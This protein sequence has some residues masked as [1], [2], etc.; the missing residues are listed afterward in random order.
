MAEGGQRSKGGEE[1]IPDADDGSSGEEES[2]KNRRDKDEISISGDKLSFNIGKAW[3]TVKFQIF[4]NKTHCEYEATK[5]V[6]MCK[7]QFVLGSDIEK[8]NFLRRLTKD[9]K[10]EVLSAG[11]VEVSGE[12]AKKKKIEAVWSTLIMSVNDALDGQVVE[13]HRFQSRRELENI[14]QELDARIKILIVK[15]IVGILTSYEDTTCITKFV[16]PQKDI[17]TLNKGLYHAMANKKRSCTGKSDEFDISIDISFDEGIYF[18]TMKLNEQFLEK[19]PHVRLEKEENNSRAYKFTCSDENYLVEAINWFKGSMNKMSR[20]E[21]DFSSKRF[22]NISESVQFYLQKC[23]HKVPADLIILPDRIYI[24]CCKSNL[25]SVER[26]VAD[27]IKSVELEGSLFPEAEKIQKD[28]RGKIQVFTGNKPGMIII[29]YTVDKSAEAKE[30]IDLVQKY[31][32]YKR[33]PYSDKEIKAMKAL[34]VIKE[35]QEE[36]KDILIR[37]KDADVILQGPEMDRVDECFEKLDTIVQQIKFVE[38][39]SLPE[40]QQK[41]LK[42]GK[43]QT[44]VTEKLKGK[45]AFCEDGKTVTVFFI[46]ENENSKSNIY[47]EI[48]SCFVE[49]KIDTRCLEHGKGKS[50]LSEHPEEVVIGDQGNKTS[51]IICYTA[52]L[53]QEIEQLLYSYSKSCT[54]IVANYLLSF[55][56]KCLE[57]IKEKHKVGIEI[58]N[59]RICVKGQYNRGKNVVTE[60]E[61]HLNTTV[62]HFGKLD[63]KRKQLL[64]ADKNQIDSVVENC[65]CCLKAEVFPLQSTQTE[66]NGI[67][68]LCTW[69]LCQ[70]KEQISIAEIDYKTA[71]LDGLIILVNECLYGEDISGNGERCYFADQSHQPRLRIGDSKEMVLKNKYVCVKCFALVASESGLTENKQTRQ[72]INGVDLRKFCSDIFAK[73]FREGLYKVGFALPTGDPNLIGKLDAVIEA[74]HDIYTTQLYDN[75]PDSELIFGVKT[76]AERWMQE[77]DNTLKFAPYARRNISPRYTGLLNSPCTSVEIAKKSILETGANC[78]VVAISPDLNLSKGFVSSLVSEACGKRL[79]AELSSKYKKAPE[80]WDLVMCQSY[81]LAEKGI[82]KVIF[83]FIPHWTDCQKIEVS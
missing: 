29:W 57:E 42:N 31:R 68:Y 69:N 56:A 11:V 9:I 27:S 70:S 74:F 67:E 40:L 19:F 16:G 79:Q 82:Q 60:I 17:E 53:S 5:Q 47:F 33:K 6:D 46:R 22:I 4:I 55:G 37:T 32:K 41:L 58:E 44:Y 25:Q 35:L 18:E 2:H 50:F 54:S 8:I 34:G 65:R 52:D 14:L 13:S 49:M 73:M 78:I 1:N 7:L 61:S 26:I 23:L 72:Y 43:V 75:T 20:F 76:E 80:C 45:I 39:N 66:E 3:E 51:C 81:N 10:F 24:L 83:G 64:A 21:L 30:L 48:K 12:F 62:L 77:V 71:K 28:S 59:D 15:G 63:Y 38:L 36:Y